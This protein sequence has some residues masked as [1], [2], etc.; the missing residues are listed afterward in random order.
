MTGQNSIIGLRLRGY[1]PSDVWVVV[2]DTEPRYFEGTHPE[3][4]LSSGFLAQIDVLPTDNPATLDFRCLHGLRA[5][6]VGDNHR[7]VRAVFNRIQQFDPAEI[8]AVTD[9]LLHWKPE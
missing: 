5:H 8:L 1:S 7:R 9:D 6:V 4:L 3:N 2:L